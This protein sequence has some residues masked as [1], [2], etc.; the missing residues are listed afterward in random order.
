[1]SPQYVN[2][3]TK[4]NQLNLSGFSE[5]STTRQFRAHFSLKR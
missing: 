2:G 1:L 4:N 5:Q 3:S